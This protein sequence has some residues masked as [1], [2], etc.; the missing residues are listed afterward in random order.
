MSFR[1]KRIQALMTSLIVIAGASAHASG[2]TPVSGVLI[3]GLAVWL[4]F[5]VIKKLAGAMLIRGVAT[6]FIVPMALAK[7]LVLVSVP[8]V[9]LLLPRSLVDGVSFAI[10]VTTLPMAV[11]I[12][13]CLPVPTTQTG[14]A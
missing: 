8:A 1:L 14:D 12:D 11:V 13:A 5:V 4:D 6:S 2:S 9:A 7:S 3:G 10:G